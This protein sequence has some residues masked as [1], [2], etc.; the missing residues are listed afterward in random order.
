M[1]DK[2]TEKKVIKG[3]TKKIRT[4][5]FDSNFSR[6][7]KP[8]TPIIDSPTD[9]VSKNI[10]NEILYSDVPLKAKKKNKNFTKMN[11][12][13]TKKIKNRMTKRNTTPSRSNRKRGL[14][15]SKS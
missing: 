9:E 8:L 6:D 11:K 13:K 7:S 10:K 14:S 4:S 12:L 1:D 2:H 3:A 15:S 5:K